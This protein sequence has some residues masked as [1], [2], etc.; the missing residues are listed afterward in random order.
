MR[1]QN[2]IGF[3]FSRD[4]HIDLRGKLTHH[5]IGADFCCLTWK[6]IIFYWRVPKTSTSLRCGASL[7]TCISTTLTSAWAWST[8][9]PSS[10]ATCYPTGTSGFTRVGRDP[11]SGARQAKVLCSNIKTSLSWDTFRMRRT[12]PCSTSL[13]CH[14]APRTWLRRYGT[15]YTC[16]LTEKGRL[17]PTQ[18]HQP[19]WSS[20]KLLLSLPLP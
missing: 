3:Q 19:A 9:A 7:T 12:T 4:L 6:M 2:L 17:N 18:T 8:S 14:G 15:S 10:P 16:R 20:Q 1:P 13:W 5:D 11:T